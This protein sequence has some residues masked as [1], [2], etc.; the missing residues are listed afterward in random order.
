MNTT[1]YIEEC[2]RL[3]L[4]KN[5]TYEP[6]K[7]THYTSQ[8]EKAQDNNMNSFYDTVFKKKINQ[9]FFSPQLQSIPNLQ[10]LKRGYNPN[11]R[12]KKIV[13]PSNKKIN[14]KTTTR[15]EPK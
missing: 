3:Q 8:T 15:H 13:T 12:I 9:D 2:K 14:I 10:K 5:E 11:M 7:Y 1:S 6:S 4:D